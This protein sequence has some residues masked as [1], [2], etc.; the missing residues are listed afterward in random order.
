MDFMLIYLAKASGILALFLGVYL[1][2]LKRETFFEANRHFLLGG[3]LISF[4]LP[5]IEIKKYVAVEPLVIPNADMIQSGPAVSAIAEQGPGWTTLLS[6]VYFS[7]LIF[8]GLRFLMQLF[9]LSRLLRNHEVIKMG[10]VRYVETDQ[11]LAPF[12]FFNYIVYNPSQ[13][14]ESELEAIRQHERAHC[15]QAHSVDILLAHLLTIFLWIN[16]LSWLYRKHIQQNLE[17]LAD[18]SAIRETRSVRNYQYALLKVS[19][20]SIHTPITNQFYSSLIKKRIVMLHKSKSNRLHALKY[21]LILPLLAGF[22]LAF[23]TKVV[24]QE[25][26]KEM[27]VEVMIDKIEILIDKDYSK[28]QIDA[29]TDFIKKRGIELKFKGIK[30]NK[31]GEITAIS[32]SYKDENGIIGNYSQNSDSPIKPFSFSVSGEGD[33]RIIGFFSGASHHLTHSMDKNHTKMII[34]DADD[35]MH[36]GKHHI[37]KKMRVLSE[38]DKGTY[39]WTTSG[40]A[41]EKEILVEIRDGKKVIKIN[42]EE[43]SEAELEAM[44]KEEDEKR[45]V[46]RKI[47]KGEEGNVFILR[48]SM[49]EGDMEIIEEEGNSFFFL[50]SG[51]GENPL[52]IVDGKEMSK[53]EFEGLS[54]GKIE[55]VEVLKGEAATKEFGDRAKDGVIRITT[56]KS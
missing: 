28:E 51:K 54:P 30:R 1:F 41:A 10:S 39:T 9:S 12:S 48:D 47:K 44:E 35:D 23:N 17:F 52:F 15:T 31:A 53:E 34:I 18:S 33:D 50:D 14:S 4:I 27:T 42:G 16:P 8:L 55:K 7:G 21:S 43:V 36:D 45:I 19:S 29:D 3:I 25:K 11:D 46:I 24:A 49:D 37:H 6:A 13:F 22:L 26:E 38:D 56:K 40:D 20:K 32:A 2:F 5:F